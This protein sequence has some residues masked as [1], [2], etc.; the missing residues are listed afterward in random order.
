[1]L[2]F[3][4]AM[5]LELPGCSF[6]SVERLLFE[7][8]KEVL[9]KFARQERLL[10]QM[11]AATTTF[12][13]MQ[14]SADVKRWTNSYEL[15]GMSPRSKAVSKKVEE[16]L[17]AKES[18]EERLFQSYSAFDLELRAEAE[19]IH[20]ERSA[21]SPSWGSDVEETPARSKPQSRLRR[22]VGHPS[23]DIFFAMVVLLNA[24]FLGMEVESQLSGY[25]LSPMTSRISNYIFATL[26]TVELLARVAAYGYDFL[27]SD[28][29]A[30][31]LL[32]MFIVATSLAEIGAD[33][34]AASSSD[35]SNVG[36]V[37]GFKVFRMIR[38]TRIVK[39][40]RVVRLVRFVIALRTLVTSIVH[41]L[42][43][44]LIFKELWVSFEIF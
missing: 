22:M 21:A 11:S 41:T 18:K 30:W 28:D 27:W 9:K 20:R 31:N 25:W 29:W 2:L 35:S 13:S 7:Q 32:D 1:M 4:Q 39:T 24:I 36:S 12:E 40:V 14:N 16:T 19:Y 8:H 44:S 10:T 3:R 15:R 23:F 33:I 5:P 43:A 38:L 37:T 34:V 26:F 17:G 6:E 42:K